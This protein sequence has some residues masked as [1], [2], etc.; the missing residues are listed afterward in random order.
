MRDDMTDATA[1]RDIPQSPSQPDANSSFIVKPP[2]AM[3]YEKVRLDDCC[4]AA[5]CSYRGWHA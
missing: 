1:V 4:D 2:K 5:L 3:N